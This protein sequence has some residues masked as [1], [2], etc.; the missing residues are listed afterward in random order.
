MDSVKAKE[1]G[2]GEEWPALAGKK[3]MRCQSFGQL[4]G[5]PFMINIGEEFDADHHVA[6][7]NSLCLTFDAPPIGEPMPDRS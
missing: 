6:N 2:E 7:I 1:R 5:I 3:Y 4:E